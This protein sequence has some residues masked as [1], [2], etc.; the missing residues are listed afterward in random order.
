MIGDPRIRTAVFGLAVPLVLVAATELP[1]NRRAWQQNT[2]YQRRFITALRIIEEAS[3]RSIVFI[4]YGPKHEPDLSLIWNVPD[5]AEARIWLAHNRGADNIRLMRL[6][7][8][9]RAFVFRAHEG[10][11]LPVPPVAVLER[12]TSLGVR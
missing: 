3:P 5:L 6:A 12:S 1:R 8:E 11:I 10:R 2:S 7:P 4:D 9:R